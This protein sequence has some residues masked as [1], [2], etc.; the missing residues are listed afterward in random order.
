MQKKKYKVKLVDGEHYIK[1]MSQEELYLLFEK[2]K[3]ARLTGTIPP[4]KRLAG[5]ML[6]K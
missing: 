6:V 3:S 2:H 4:N 1:A 5:I